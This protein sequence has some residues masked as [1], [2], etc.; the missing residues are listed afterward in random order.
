M[1]DRSGRGWSAFAVMIVIATALVPFMGGC[2]GKCSTCVGIV[3][4]IITTSSSMGGI[5]NRSDINAAHLCDTAFRD[6][7][8]QVLLHEII[9]EI[10]DS[11]YTLR[12]EFMGGVYGETIT[13]GAYSRGVGGTLYFIFT[14]NRDGLKLEDLQPGFHWRRKAYQAEGSDEPLPHL[15]KFGR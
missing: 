6:S 3:H 11:G 4:S 7:L 8:R 9:G 13:V 2:G 10:R 1:F 5:C 14:E 12:C 15:V